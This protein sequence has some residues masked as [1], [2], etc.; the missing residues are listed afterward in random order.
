MRGL[1]TDGPPK[2]AYGHRWLRQT[3][4]SMLRFHR[5]IKK[6]WAWSISM[7][8]VLI[9]GGA[10]KTHGTPSRIHWCSTISL[11][12]PAP[13]EIKKNINTPPRLAL[14][15]NADI[16]WH[17]IVYHRSTRYDDAKI[18]V[19]RYATQSKTKVIHHDVPKEWSFSLTWFWL[20]RVDDCQPDCDG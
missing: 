13:L 11:N 10:S 15:A 18:Y 4:H 16:Q 8:P 3:E 6:N 14:T 2:V 9:C 1:E 12:R 20:P 7:L 17:T 5:R 19:L